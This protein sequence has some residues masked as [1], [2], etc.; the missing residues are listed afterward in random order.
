MSKEKGGNFDGEGKREKDVLQAPYL[1][2]IVCFSTDVCNETK[3][4]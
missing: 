3:R 2:L 1:D 4:I